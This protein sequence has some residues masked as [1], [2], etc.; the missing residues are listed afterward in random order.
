MSRGKKSGTHASQPLMKEDIGRCSLSVAAAVVCEAARLCL[1]GVACNK[2]AIRRLLSGRSRRQKT[3]GRRR[4][5]AR[6]GTAALE[7]SWRKKEEE[8]KHPFIRHPRDILSLLF[9]AFSFKLL[10]SWLPH[11][12]CGLENEKNVHLIPRVLFFCTYVFTSIVRPKI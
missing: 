9:H 5:T 7:S 10:F 6:R 11:L 2:N 8:R 12:F 1:F 4:I 3:R